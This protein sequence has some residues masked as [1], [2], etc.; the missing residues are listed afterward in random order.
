VKTIEQNL[1]RL[2]QEI[3]DCARKYQRD[4]DDITLLAV[5]K[6][7]PPEAL[8]AARRA[9]QSDFGENYLQE[10]QAKIEALAGEDCRWHFIGALQ[11]NKTREVATY[12]DWVHTLD[13]ARIARRLNDQRPEGLA[14][15]SVCIQ[16]NISGEA[17]KSGVAPAELAALAETVAGLPRLVLRGLMTLP[18]PARDLAAQRRPFAELRAAFASLRANGHEL[19]TLS[20][21]T[22]A[23]REA[24]IAEGATVLRL[25]T[26]IFGPR[27]A[28]G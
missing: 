1:A 25:G 8:L 19:D 15:L 9:G 17:S 6:K 18:A 28:D 24:A 26:A 3:R 22:T 7:Q 20:M 2:R 4:P 13:R 5:S 27:P 23:D 11:S 10:A 12:F 21:G 16:V 14:P